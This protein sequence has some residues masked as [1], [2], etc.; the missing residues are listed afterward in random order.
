M[1]SVMSGGRRSFLGITSTFRKNIKYYNPFISSILNF[2][3][4]TIFCGCTG[5]ARF[6]SNLVR[7]PENRFSHDAV[8]INLTRNSS[9][10]SVVG[11]SVFFLMMLFI[12]I[13]LGIQVNTVLL[14]FLFFFLMMRF[15]SILLGIQVNTVLLGFLF[16]LMMLFI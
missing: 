3:P 10:H 11:F 14:G 12:S 6:V 1:F 5:T 16:F 13:L 15:I 7:N 4:L 2:K 9:K 8:R